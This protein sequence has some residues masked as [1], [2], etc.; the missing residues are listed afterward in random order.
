MPVVKGGFQIPVD[1]HYWNGW[2]LNQS[3]KFSFKSQNV[4]PGTHKYFKNWQERGRCNK[5][6][7]CTNVAKIPP[8]PLE[9][10][11]LILTQSLECSSQPATVYSTWDG[12]GINMG[13]AEWTQG[14]LGL[15]ILRG[16][17]VKTKTQTIRPKIYRAVRNL[18]E[19]RTDRKQRAAAEQ[20]Y[21]SGAH[22]TGLGCS[23]TGC[24]TE[25]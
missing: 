18:K 11:K 2:G 4:P 6:L 7:W 3:I 21:S 24:L 14:A 12:A 23:S 13:V 20:Q 25:D 16:L 8:S 9:S 5:L 17:L 19:S 1:N 22:F 10:Y 15:L